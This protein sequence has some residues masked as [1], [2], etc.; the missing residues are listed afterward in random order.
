MNRTDGIENI[1]LKILVLED[2]RFDL[3]LIEVQLSDA[4]YLLDVT[5]VEN[6][7]AYIIALHEKRYD[8]ILSDFSLPGFDAYSALAIAREICPGVPFICV[9]GH[10]D[11]SNDLELRRQG[12]FGYVSKEQLEQLTTVIN[13]ALDETG[14]RSER[15]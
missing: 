3:E 6:E 12:A 7:K 11:E 13:Q 10:I 15:R 4:G 14:E 9:S 1:A 8:V 2:S 5:H